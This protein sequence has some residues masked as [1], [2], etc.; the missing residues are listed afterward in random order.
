MISLEKQAGFP[1]FLNEKNNKLHSKDIIIPKPEIRTLKQLIPVIL[2]KS[3]IKNVYYMYRNVLP[4]KIFKRYGYRYDIT[5]IPFH[6][7]GIEES[8]TLGHYHAHIRGTKI[9]YPEVYQVLYGKAYYLLQRKDKNKI[10]D[11][12]VVVAKQGDVVV[13]PPNYGHV[14]INAGPKTLVMANLVYADFSSHYREYIKKHGAAYYA[15]LK[16]KK[17]VFVKNKHYKDLPKLR[18]AKMHLFSLKSPIYVDCINC[19]YKYLFLREPQK[20]M[21]EFKKIMR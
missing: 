8:K 7:I 17:I 2:G 5:V 9:S 3:K 10:K 20:F 16:D 21:K 12:I 4:N 15:I 14:T 1:L 6:K 13:I 18:R 19:P 11:V